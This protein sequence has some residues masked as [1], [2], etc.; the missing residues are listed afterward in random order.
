[1]ATIIEVRVP[2]IGDFKG[3]EVIEVMV[4]PGDTLVVEQPMLIL[5][6]DK[7]SM[8]V[9]APEAGVVKEVKIKVGDKISRGDLILLLETETTSAAAVA[10]PMSE[11]PPVVALGPTAQKPTSF[12]ARP[13]VAPMPPVDEAAFAKV[14]ASPSVRLF[15]RELGVDLGR[16][17]E[18]SGRKGRVTKEDVQNFVKRV[19]AGEQAPAAAVVTG[20]GIPPIPPVD[21]AKFGDIETVPVG[22]IKRLAAVNLS[23]SWLNLPHV[24]HHDEADI[25][26]TEA[27]RKSLVEEA[28]QEDVRITLLSFLLKAAAVTLKAFPTF[29]ASLDPGGENLILKKY[30]H[31]GVAVD[32]PEGLVVPVIRD[33]DRK[34]ILELS[35]ELG[36]YSAKARAKKLMPG[37]MQGAGFTISS[38]GGIG[39]KFFT[40]IINAPEV[41]ILGVTQSYMAPVWNG[42]EF[43]PRLLLPLSLSY[44]HRVIDGAQAARFMNHFCGLVGDI[45]RLLL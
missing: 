23:R 28:K 19:L 22:R 40:P 30:C 18:G 4:S 3:V 16:I 9:P 36:E 32:T 2:D 12:E 11:P 1:M 29:N 17:R 43:L 33:V 35:R 21:F 42:R 15:A 8:E 14:H 10:A 13:P 39:G 44:D 26:E 41:A 7:A 5:E 34:T 38:L 20:T 45:R 27:F 24:T 25:T 31:I 6:S 37:E